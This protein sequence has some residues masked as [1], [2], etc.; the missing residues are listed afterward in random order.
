MMFQPKSPPTW[1]GG[2]ITFNNITSV[3]SGQSSEQTQFNINDLFTLEPSDLE[4]EIIDSQNVL[5]NSS[6]ILSYNGTDSTSGTITC[7]AKTMPDVFATIDYTTHYQQKDHAYSITSSVFDSYGQWGSFVVTQ[8]ASCTQ[9]GEQE[10]SRDV[11][12]HDEYKCDFCSQTY[13][14]EKYKKDTETETETIS[15]LGHDYEISGYTSTETASSGT[16]TI[17]K[18]ATCTTSGTKQISYAQWNYAI[19]TCSRCSDSY[20]DSSKHTLSPKVVTE[21]ISAL[22]HD[23]EITGYTSTETASSG[24]SKV[25]KSATC[26]STG[27]KQITYEQWNYAIYDCSRCSASYESST[28]NMLSPKVV[29]Q[30]ISALGHDYE[31]TGYTSTETASTGT[32]TITKA[33]TCTTSGTKKVSYAQWN[34]AIYECTR[35]SDSYTSSTKHTL[36]PKVETESI[37]AL[38]HKYETTPSSYSYRST[39]Q[40]YAYRYCTN[41]RCTER[42]VSYVSH[43]ASIDSSTGFRRC[44]HCDNYIWRYVD[45]STKVTTVTHKTGWGTDNSSIS[46]LWSGA[47]DALKNACSNVF[48]TSTYFP[49]LSKCQSMAKSTGTFSWSMG[50][51]YMEVTISAITWEYQFTMK[52]TYYSKYEARSTIEHSTT[53][54]FTYTGYYDYGAIL[55]ETQIDFYN[56]R[57]SDYPL[58]G[59]ITSSAGNLSYK[60]WLTSVI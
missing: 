50:G 18:A 38:G 17:T 8:P 54:P 31:I 22:G 16:E 28:K 19:H 55:S 13:S 27:T 11:Y 43:Y 45:F 5:T 15:A 34:Y 44:N 1:G 41:S 52:L 4:I 12:Y 47:L 60:G 56:G 48:T 10:H 21:T 6:Q 30:T 23:Y 40:D 51:Y 3:C 7:R 58:S 59:L 20:T 36:S 29:T 26:T 35:C 46:S 25:I 33:A 9:N 49:T 37:P 2:G 24:T 32:E 39:T 14:S 57:R 53:D 42:Q